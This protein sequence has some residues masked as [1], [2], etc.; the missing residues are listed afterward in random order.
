MYTLGCICIGILIAFGM[1][2]ALLVLASRAGNWERK[3]KTTKPGNE[4]SRLACYREL[5]TDRAAITSA[6][7][8]GRMSTD[9]ANDKLDQLENQIRTAY[10]AL[11][12]WEKMMADCEEGEEWKHL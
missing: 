10:H 12:D 7:A 3:T 8:N 4:P 2:V 11:S 1:L 9:E 6:L 5:L